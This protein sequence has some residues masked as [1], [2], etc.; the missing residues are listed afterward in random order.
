M[1]KIF[2][3]IAIASLLCCNVS[4]AA[5]NV[6][7][8]RSSAGDTIVEWQMDDVSSTTGW[9]LLA[10]NNLALTEGR[11]SATTYVPGGLSASLNFYNVGSYTPLFNSNNTINELISG[12]AFALIDNTSIVTLGLESQNSGMNPSY[13]NFSG[14][15]TVDGT[16]L[17]NNL[18]VTLGSSR[19]V[20]SIVGSTGGE[21]DIIFTKNASIVSVPEPSSTFLIILGGVSLLSLRRRHSA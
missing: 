18:Q 17:F 12:D 13:T 8:S 7:F 20:S 14:N 11:G 1:F 15:V 10:Q 16:R 6:T 19:T 3:T 4:N 2:N 21:G 5:L 9:S